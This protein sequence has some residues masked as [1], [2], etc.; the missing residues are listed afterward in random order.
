MKWNY[1][2]EKEKQK[3]LRKIWNSCQ[4]QFK[5]TDICLTKS[6][7]SKTKKGLVL[8]YISQNCPELVVIAFECWTVDKPDAFCLIMFLFMSNNRN[9][10]LQFLD[11]GAS[12]QMPVN[13][14]ALIAECCP[15]GQL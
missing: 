1:H 11:L 2:A 4:E 12:C 9:E 6:N 3:I 5:Q 8:Y 7:K 15:N 14:S 13:W 10:S